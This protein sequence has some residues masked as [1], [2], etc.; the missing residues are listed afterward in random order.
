MNFWDKVLRLFGSNRVQLAWRWRR[1]K[2]GWDKPGSSRPK[3]VRAGGLIPEEF[4]LVSS[5]LVGL[6]V[7]FYFLTVKITNDSTGESGVS[8]SNLALVRYGAVYTPLLTE[9]GE[10]WRLVS[11][12]FLHAGFMH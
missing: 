9:G 1:F 12:C 11:S 7:V 4:P 5:L 2:E 8:P 10:W 6:C 3:T